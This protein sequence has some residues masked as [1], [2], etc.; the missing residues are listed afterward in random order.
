M[1]DVLL[2][3]KLIVMEFKPAD[4]QMV[5]IDFFDCIVHNDTTTTVYEVP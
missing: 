3:L 1:K 4:Y 2:S 5:L